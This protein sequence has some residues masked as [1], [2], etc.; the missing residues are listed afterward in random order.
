MSEVSN[1]AHTKLRLQN[2]RIAMSETLRDVERRNEALL[3]RTTNQPVKGCLRSM[4]FDVQVRGS[5]I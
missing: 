3:F 4:V 1:D 2:M 5:L